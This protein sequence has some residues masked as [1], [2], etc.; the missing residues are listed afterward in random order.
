MRSKAFPRIAAAAMLA[1]VVAALSPTNPLRA[2]DEFE[3]HHAHEHGVATLSIAFENQRLDLKLESPAINVVGFEHAPH[4]SAELELTTKAATRLGEAAKLFV[5]TAA[6]GC[7]VV[8]AV[9]S[10]PEWKSAGKHADYDAS[11]EYECSKP[12]ALTTVDVRL[13]DA[14]QPGT[15]IRAQIVTTTS[16]SA[17]ELTRDNTLIKLQ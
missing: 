12:Q 5:L 16:Q 7:R 6:A 4:S 14:L 10:P 15:K 3:T 9:V 8:S 13:F 2:H 17:L 11:Y 1:A